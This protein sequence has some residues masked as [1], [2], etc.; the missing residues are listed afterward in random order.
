MTHRTTARVVGGLFIA[1]DVAGGLGMMLNQSVAGARDQLTAASL[2][3]NRV[4]TAALLE[5]AMGMAVAG[6]AIAIYPVLRRVGERLALGY[7]AVRTMEGMLAVIGALGWL[8]LLTVGKQYVSATTPAASFQNLGG[9]LSAERDWVLHAVLPIVFGLGALILNYIL[10]QTRLVPRWLPV[11]GLGGAALWL[12]A[13][14][15]VTYGVGSM[16][17]LAAPIGLQEIALALWLIFK[18][19][20]AAAFASEPDAATTP[21]REA[22]SQLGL[23]AGS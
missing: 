22:R 3:A 4:A 13:R 15:M 12:A 8:T 7:V 1:A 18:G 6:I 21:G 5:L 20:D 16:T 11:W 2:N 17:V 14:V 19:F 23:I 9:M 10:Y